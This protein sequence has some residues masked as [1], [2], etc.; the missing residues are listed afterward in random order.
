MADLI[1]TDAKLR[2]RGGHMD[3]AVAEAAE[4]PASRPEQVT[5]ILA[6]AYDTIDGI[7]ATAD[8]ARSLACA[9]REWLLQQV[10]HDFCPDL[11][12]FEVTC[13]VCG[14][15]FDVTLKLSDSV[16]QRPDRPVA[17]VTVETSLGTR[18][19]D[20]PNGY[21]EEAFARQAPDVAGDPRRLFAE[22]CGTSDQAATEAACFDT[23]DLEL[24]D[25][26]LE[27]ASPDVAD[28]ITCPCP[29]CGSTT[30][31]RI[32]PLHFAFPREADILHDTHVIARAY[33][34]SLE[35]ILAL[36]SRHRAFFAQSVTRDRSAG[37]R[38]RAR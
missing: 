9:D 38:R 15:P 17:Q 11:T 18:T 1:V 36:S 27:A 23:H 4:R 19:F 25:E 22:L 5:A 13:G 32:D 33:G 6:A 34:W 20:I 14:K 31:A 10:A 37:G 12:W 29:N 2:P 24:I 26:A 3:L 21:H 28:E 8:A 35:E 16:V 7:P 30:A